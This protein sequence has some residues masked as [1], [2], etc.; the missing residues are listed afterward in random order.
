MESGESMDGID[1]TSS[2][3]LLKKSLLRK[4]WDGQSKLT[5]P[6]MIAKILETMQRVRDP[7]AH[8]KA[9]DSVNEQFQKAQMEIQEDKQLIRQCLD[10]AQQRKES[11]QVQDSPELKRYIDEEAKYDEGLRAY[12][13]E[14]GVPSHLI[15]KPTSPALIRLSALERMNGSNKRW[16]DTEDSAKIQLAELILRFQ[17]KRPTLH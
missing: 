8:Q 16:L 1:R 7:D 2:T 4:A 12:L 5:G 10:W 13:K 6:E 3:Y 11:G 9:V 14:M 15:P 17:H